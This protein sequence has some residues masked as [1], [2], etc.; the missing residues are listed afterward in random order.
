MGGQGKS[1][2]SEESFPGL[3]TGT[4]TASF[5]T[6][7]S[8]PVSQIWLNSFNTISSVFSVICANIL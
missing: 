5:H 7:G 3:R 2:G 1:I 6:K 4:I 8:Y